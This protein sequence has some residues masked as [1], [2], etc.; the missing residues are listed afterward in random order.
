M[1]MLHL[2]HMFLST[3]NFLDIFDNLLSF[4]QN[5]QGK[6]IFGIVALAIALLLIYIIYHFIDGIIAFLKLLILFIF[7]LIRAILLV[8][9]FVIYSIIAWMFIIPAKAFFQHQKMATLA[10]QYQVSVIKIWNWIYPKSKK[11]IPLTPTKIQADSTLK[12]EKDAK[13]K[14]E[15]SERTKETEKSPDKKGTAPSRYHCSNCGSPMNEQ[16]I[17]LLSNHEI[18][19]CDECG[20]KFKQEGGEPFPIQD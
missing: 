1:F 4:L 17:A 10:F 9:V 19:F 5:T 11:A 3:I 8:I 6:I 14:K 12:A 20:Q 16:M 18:A 2:T 7:N 15:K 13:A